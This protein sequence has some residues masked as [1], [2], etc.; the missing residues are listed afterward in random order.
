[1]SL[2][3]E[4][5]DDMKEAMR[6]KDADRLSVLRMVKAKLT[7]Q[8]IDSGS[9]LSDEETIKTLKTLVKQRRDSAD[10]YQKAGREEL[11][12]KELSEISVIEHYLPNAATPEEIEKA[13][14]D[15]ISETGAESMKD[16][17]NVMKAALAMLSDKTVDGKAVSE[18][19]RVKLQ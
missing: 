15:A 9:E 2:K 12:D 13:V 14:A 3:D 6:S 7:N 8:E 1:M 18:I 4:I 19:V 5:F 17:G 16:M 11:A 10:Q